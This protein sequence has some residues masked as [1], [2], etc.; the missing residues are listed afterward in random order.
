M[1]FLEIDARIFIDTKIVF[2]GDDL[3]TRSRFP[4]FD[5]SSEKISNKSFM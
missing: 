5:S 2:D 4:S 3:T 1:I